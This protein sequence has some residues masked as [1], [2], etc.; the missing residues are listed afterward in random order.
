MITLK[1]AKRILEDNTSKE[2]TE[3]E[4]KSI[5]S[6][7]KGFADLIIE[8]KQKKD[9]KSRGKEGDNLHKG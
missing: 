1:K 8:D 7:L 2:Y 3:D 6:K 9:E 4:V 5:V